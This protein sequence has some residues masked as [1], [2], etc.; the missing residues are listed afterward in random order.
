M[1]FLGVYGNWW[2]GAL[3]ISFLFCFLF[4]V[5]LHCFRWKMDSWMMAVGINLFIVAWVHLTALLTR[6]G[7]EWNDIPARCS[8]VDCLLTLMKVYSGS[9]VWSSMPHGGQGEVVLSV[10]YYN[11]CLTWLWLQS[12][13]PCSLV[14]SS[15]HTIRL[16]VKGREAGLWDKLKQWP[17]SVEQ[18]KTPEQISQGVYCGQPRLKCP[19]PFCPVLL[20]LGFF[21][22]CYLSLFSNFRLSMNF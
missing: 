5:S 10:C 7:R 6:M 15:Y 2:Q 3:S 19:I 22:L 8:W 9:T 13:S 14:L 11:P 16:V 17:N 4:Q 21:S 12:C 20:S 1:F 18:G